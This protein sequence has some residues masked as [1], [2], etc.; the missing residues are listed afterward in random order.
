MECKK[1]NNMKATWHAFVI[2]VQNRKKQTKSK[3]CIAVDILEYL[4]MGKQLM[5]EYTRQ[6]NI[7]QSA[8]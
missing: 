8:Y 2:L 1:L 7:Q 3:K 6:N 5:L 4:Q